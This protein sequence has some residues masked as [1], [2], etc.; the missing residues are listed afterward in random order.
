[1][2]VGGAAIT[3]EFHPGFKCPTLA[4][5]TG[6]LRPDV[7]R[8]MQ[9]DR[10]GLVLIR[11]EVRVFAPHPDGR[12]LFLF[13]DA[14]RSAQSIAPFSAKDAEKYKELSGTLSRIGKVMAQALEMVPPSI[15]HPSSGDLWN[16]LKVGRGLRGLG[17]KEMYH[18]FRW[19]P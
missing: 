17:R 7:A 19:G 6:P 15:D 18:V 8:D 2:A 14:G 13:D 10:H 12:A 4:H 1:P 3:D 16:L 5:T 11:P 9:L